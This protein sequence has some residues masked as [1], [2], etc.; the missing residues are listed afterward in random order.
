MLTALS[1]VPA[2]AHVIELPNKLP[3]PREEY[4]TVQ[5]VY[6][7]WQFAGIVVVAALLATLWL[8][9][10]ADGNARAP[11]SLRSCSARTGA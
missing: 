1:L 5:R 3:M 9:L 8:A 7:G 11:R 4:L 6:R 2:A 10:L